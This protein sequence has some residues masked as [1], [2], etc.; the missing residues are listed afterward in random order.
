MKEQLQLIGV[1]TVVVIV[2][3]IGYRYFFTKAREASVEPKSSDQL[4]EQ[5]SVNNFDGID[6][7]QIVSISF[8][9]S[10]IQVEVVR[11]PASLAQGLSDRETIGSDGMLFLMPN[12]SVPSFWMKSML[13]DLDIIWIDGDTVIDISYNVPKPEPNTQFEDLPL[14]RPSQPATKVLEVVAG[15]ATEFQIS[16]GDELQLLAVE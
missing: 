6:N 13:M 9:K 15:K 1:I 3:F 5:Q 11:E 12:R 2:A 7:N 4:L 8:G 14:Y 10:P 16:I